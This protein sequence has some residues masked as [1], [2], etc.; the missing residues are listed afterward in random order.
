MGCLLSHKV[1]AKAA[2]RGPWASAWPG[3]WEARISPGHVEEAPPQAERA[4]GAKT[5]HLCPLPGYFI[6]IIFL[7]AFSSECAQEVVPSEAGEVPEGWRRVACRY[8]TGYLWG[9][10]RPECLGPSG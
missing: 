10:G 4:V 8:L 6:Y 7:F 5:R 1:K 2:S 9:A 3:F